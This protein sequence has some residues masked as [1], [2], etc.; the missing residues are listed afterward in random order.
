MAS[1]AHCAYCFETLAADLENRKALSF[2][3]VLELWAQHE[4]VRASNAP[5]V[6]YGDE[7]DQDSGDVEDGDSVMDGTEDE[8]DNEEVGER[9]NITPTVPQLPSIS[10]LQAL[11]PAPASSSSSTP[12]SLSTA[13]SSSALGGN[14]QTSSNSSFFSFGRSKQPSPAGLLKV[15]EH[16][17]FVTWNTVSQRTGHHSLRG[18]I[19]TFD[20][21]ELS[22]G[23]KSYALTA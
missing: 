8:D 19:G 15:E 5:G 20:P 18:C 12:L 16:P 4:V 3:Q 11:S 21:Q 2:Q 23:L 10:R 6:I 14:S 13:S 17:L 22:D 1:S 7:Q 9:H